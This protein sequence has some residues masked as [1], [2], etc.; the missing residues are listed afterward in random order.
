MKNFDYEVAARVDDVF[1]S[2]GDQAMVIAGGTELLNWF[3]LG[4][5]APD[6]V[7]DI[8]RIPGL[9]T[10]ERSRNELSIGA[11]ATLNQIGEHPLVREHAAVLGTAC[12]KAASAQIRN[13]ATIGGN[14][15]QKT[16]CPYFRAEQPLPWGCNKR[17]PGTGCAARE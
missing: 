1:A 9:D 13:R 3:R 10:I 15:L 8:G 16:R 2:D 4:I 7:I 17:A 11:L 14:V 6:K 5:V 12:L